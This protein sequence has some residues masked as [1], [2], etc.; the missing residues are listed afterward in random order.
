MIDDQVVR[1]QTLF[2]NH[3]PALR[4]FVMALTSDFSLVDDIMQETFLTISAKADKFQPGTSFRAWA[5]AV[6]RLK[7]LEALRKARR[8]KHLAADVIESLCSHDEAFDW[9][10]ID[11]LQR[12][13]AA[14]VESLAAKAK[15][16]VEL[17]YKQGHAAAEIARQM[18]WTTNAIHVALSRARRAIRE[19]VQRRLAV[20]G[21]AG[22]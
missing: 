5:W 21:A 19:C 4:G 8:E 11:L 3:M 15:T 18:G 17:R 7:T 13:V 10:E 2:V 6:A 20:P 14:C 1:V 12:Q 16:V 9:S 22:T